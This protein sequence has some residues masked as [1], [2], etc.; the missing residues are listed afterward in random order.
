M[1]S[2][3]GVV[4]YNAEQ[5]DKTQIINRMNASMKYRGPDA[6][7]TLCLPNVC[8][9]HNRLAIIDLS[10]GAQPMSVTHEG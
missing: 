5:K 9:G 2:I 3:C 6:S 10:G 8:L 7:G 1:C 4:E